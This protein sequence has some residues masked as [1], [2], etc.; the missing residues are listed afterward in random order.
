[1]KIACVQLQPA[2]PNFWDIIPAPRYGTLVVT[3]ALAQAGFEVTGLVEGISSDIQASLEKA[4]VVAFTV[5]TSSARK[6]Y[7][8]A[9]RLRRQGKVVVFG[10]THTQYFLDDC[11]PHCDYVGLG[12]GEDTLVKLVTALEAGTPIDGIPGLAWR[13]NGDV[14][15]NARSPSPRRYQGITNCDLIKDYPAFIRRRRRL[16]WAPIT[17]QATRGCPFDCSFCV[18]KAMFGETYYTRP[19]E[20]VIAELKDKLRYSRDIYF[21]DNNFA[22]NLA[23]TRRLLD[24]LRRERLNMNAT[25]YV[26]HEF[27]KNRELL[28]AMREAGFTRLLTGIESFSDKSLADMKKHQTFRSLRQSVT[29]FKEFGFRVSGT[30]IMGSGEETP[31]T[32]ARYLAVARDLNLDY[33]Y[34]FA[35]ALYPSMCTG[36][37]TRD[38]IFMQD[39]DW[40]T[41]HFI[42]FFP[43]RIRPSRLQAELLKA[44]LGFYSWRRIIG[45][46][47]RFRLKDVAEL[48]LHRR[49]FTRLR[50]YMQQYGTFLAATE[51]GLYR[52][53]ELDRTALTA[54]DVP[55][56]VSYEGSRSHAGE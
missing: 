10:G 4:D 24:A 40:G 35:Y 55:K 33:A 25:V 2:V 6:S 28:G 52:G 12:D 13:E 53:E 41:G 29:I 27:A 54:R 3:S 19:V 31:A 32:A 44:H 45:K 30:F 43:E 9:D 26:R 7:E 37:I 23:Y 50:P 34:F 20:E 15:S 22:G 16:G 18:A 49:L 39:F 38:R 48:F 36:D 8:L 17:V 51:R 11:L 14:R 56:H 47:L 21:V 1:M 46:A 5:L 42:F